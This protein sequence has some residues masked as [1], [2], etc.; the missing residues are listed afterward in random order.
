MASSGFKTPRGNSNLLSIY[1]RVVNHLNHPTLEVGWFQN[2]LD[3]FEVGWGGSCVSPE[4]REVVMRWFEKN[5][6]YRTM[7]YGQMWS[8]YLTS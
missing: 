3:F 5:K 6:K 7:V 2:S 8:F 1:T 4:N